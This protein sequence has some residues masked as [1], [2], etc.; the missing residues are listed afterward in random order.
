M[1][2]VLQQVAALSQSAHVPVPVV[3]VP[4]LPPP[5]VAPPVPPLVPPEPVFV[6]EQIAPASA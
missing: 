5:L 4:L 1:A 6:L 2:T 3:G